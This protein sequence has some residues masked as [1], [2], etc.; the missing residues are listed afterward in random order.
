MNLPPIDQP[1]ALAIR[2]ALMADREHS[3]A[4]ALAK[5]TN[6][7]PGAL[8]DAVERTRDLRAAAALARWFAQ[9]RV[10]LRDSDKRRGSS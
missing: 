10:G 4:Q 5:M 1:N 9:H 7:A 8:Q 2:L 6:V 3:S